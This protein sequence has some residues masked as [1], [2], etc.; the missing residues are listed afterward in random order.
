MRYCDGGIEYGFP[1]GVGRIGTLP[2][3]RGVFPRP[4]P[5]Q[6]GV[7]RF[8]FIDQNSRPVPDERLDE[9]LVTAAAFVWDTFGI[10]TV[11]MRRWFGGR[12]TEQ[13]VADTGDITIVYSGGVH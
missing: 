10:R 3:G 6:E 13:W 11:V 12:L 7:M 5:F 8:G 4:T 1:K 9:N 2:P